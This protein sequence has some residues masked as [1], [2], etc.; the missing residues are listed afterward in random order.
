MKKTFLLIFSSLF[1]VACNQNSVDDKPSVKQPKPIGE[2]FAKF[3]E[4]W[5]NFDP[6]D[7]I[8][9]EEVGII[10]GYCPTLSLFVF[11]AKGGDMLNP[12][13]PQYIDY[14]KIKQYYFDERGEKIPY[15]WNS[16][17]P[18]PNAVSLLEPNDTHKYYI[19]SMCISNDVANVTNLIDWQNGVVDTVKT[20]TEWVEFEYCTGDKYYI[21]AIR[22]VWYNGVLIW[23]PEN[24]V[25]FYPKAPYLVSYI[26]V[27]P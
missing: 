14:Q 1:F 15:F 9:M 5:P 27:M 16:T 11:D 12:V 13:H 23:D 3:P 7:S 10:G 17:I 25:C 26:K 18:K 6:A 19:A 24:E 8:D 21:H 20:E 4:V 2:W 22:K